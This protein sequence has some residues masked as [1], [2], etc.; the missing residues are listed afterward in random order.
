MLCIPYI[1]QIGRKMINPKSVSDDLTERYDVIMPN[2][3]YSRTPEQK[4]KNT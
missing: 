3:Y 2:S 1:N 4:K